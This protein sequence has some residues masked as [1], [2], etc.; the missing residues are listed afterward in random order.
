MQQSPKVA[1]ISRGKWPFFNVPDNRIF[2]IS[3]GKKWYLLLIVRD[4]D[5]FSDRWN[6]AIRILRRA[7]S[8]ICGYLRTF[9]HLSVANVGR[10][11]AAF[12]HHFGLSLMSARSVG[13]D[14][15]LNWYFFFLLL[16]PLWPSRV[17]G[18][19]LTGSLVR[20]ARLMRFGSGFLR[21]RRTMV[22]V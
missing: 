19:S 8:A 2:C 21:V 4:V 17:I 7:L 22:K 16:L 12:I 14:S 10:S 6:F 20:R 5:V 15:H 3:R 13:H 9:T 11:T 1:E 18:N